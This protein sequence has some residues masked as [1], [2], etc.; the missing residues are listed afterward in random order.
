MEL[1]H[2]LRDYQ[3]EPGIS[4]DEEASFLFEPELNQTFFA[5]SVH[6]APLITVE[7]AHIFCTF[8]MS[9]Q[10]ETSIDGVVTKRSLLDVYRRN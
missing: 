3:L 7:I 9:A 2:F 6:P 4:V 5:A 8:L 1:L 10:N